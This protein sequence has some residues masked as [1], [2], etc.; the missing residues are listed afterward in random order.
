M[1][2]KKAK[3]GSKQWK[4]YD[5]YPEVKKYSSRDFFIY[6][7]ILLMHNRSEKKKTVLFLN[8]NT[9]IIKLKDTEEKL[10]ILT[11]FTGNKVEYLIMLL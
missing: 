9:S 4:I 5:F 10:Q 2:F 11:C 3:K 7:R 6:E 8:T 1:N